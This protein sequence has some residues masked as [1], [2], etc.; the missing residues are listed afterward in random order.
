MAPQPHQNLSKQESIRVGFIPPAWKLYLLQF[1]LP[2]PDVA[3][4]GARQGVPYDVTYLIMHLMLP[5]PRG[6][7]DSF[8]NITLSQLR[9]LAVKKG[10]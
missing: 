8:E 2:P 6:Q 9:L 1:Q 10:N 7:T 4:G 3:P 5:S